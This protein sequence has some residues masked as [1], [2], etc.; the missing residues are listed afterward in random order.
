MTLGALRRFFIPGEGFF[1][2]DKSTFKL[3]EGSVEVLQCSLKILSYRRCSN[4]ATP[5]VCPM[6][7]LLH[8]SQ[9]K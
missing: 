1:K 5:C 7:F 9:Q 8:P 2:L 6:G 3:F 4:R